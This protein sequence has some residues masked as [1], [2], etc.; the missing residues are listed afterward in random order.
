MKSVLRLLALVVV[1]AVELYAVY[2]VLH[3]RVSPEYRSYYIEHSTLDWNPPHYAA[4]PEEGI[5]FER[6]GWPDFV[7]NGFGFSYREGGGRWTDATVLASPRIWM[8]RQFSGPLCIE[9]VLRPSP[10]ELGH[11]L[12]VAFGS[13]VRQLELSNRE[14]YTYRISF[15]NAQPADTLQFRFDG[16]VPLANDTRP[17]GEM[18]RRQGVQLS[19][20]KILPGRCSQP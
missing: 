14:F 13:N 2:A 6:P 20:L 7:R 5:V 15:E 17:T 1:L 4:T 10:A 11:R 16:P 19:T 8:S 3:P 18:P 9:L 12:E